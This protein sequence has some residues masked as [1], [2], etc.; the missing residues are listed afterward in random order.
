MFSWIKGAFL[1][2]VV[3]AL[4]LPLAFLIGLLAAY[5][6]FG[7]SAIG[8][9][10]IILVPF[11][12]LFGFWMYSRGSEAV[13]KAFALAGMIILVS[14]ILQFKFPGVFQLG[15]AGIASVNRA[16]ETEAL[17]I[18][19]P[20]AVPCAYPWVIG[21]AE[22]SRTRYWWS[23]KDDPV[24]CYDRP[25]RHPKYGTALFEVNGTIVELIETQ[26][27]RPTPAPPQ[28]VYATTVPVDCGNA[29]WDD[30][31]AAPAPQPSPIATPAAMAWSE[32]VIPP[33]Q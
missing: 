21:D 10:A 25:G 12:E 17:L 26:R 16:S 7:A 6:I 33:R 2:L 24:V 32:P 15:G 19:T 14:T 4:A 1:T 8:V 22:H 27:T 18:E 28:I 31:H 29:Q 20:H 3:G 9:L 5:R 11:I 30:V 23:P 13:G